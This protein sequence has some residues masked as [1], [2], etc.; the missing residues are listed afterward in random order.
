MPR[1]CVY[2]GKNKEYRKLLKSAESG[3]PDSLYRLGIHTYN[4]KYE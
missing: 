4:G 1:G 3:N 2:Y